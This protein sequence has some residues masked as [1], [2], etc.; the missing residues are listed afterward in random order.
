[1]MDKTRIALTMALEERQEI[2]D[3]ADGRLSASAFVNAVEL[4]AV[5]RDG[6]EVWHHY[7]LIG[8]VL[9]GVDSAPVGSG[10][11]FVSGLRARLALEPDLARASVAVETPSIA[12][13]TVKV[14]ISA[15]D[16]SFRWRMVAALASLTAVL[17]VGWNMVEGIQTAN[18]ARVAAL[19]GGQKDQ[20]VLTKVASGS[21]SDKGP[22][23]MLRD[24]HL[25]ALMAAHKQFG[26]TS[27]LQMPAGFIRNATFESDSK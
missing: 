24:P 16:S 8:D 15:N 14:G 22:Q 17:V 6:R 10:M 1:M 25:D 2:S 21:P 27:A 19:A 23:I 13:V 3:L 9:R 20:Q 11:D 5:N 26:G 18:G 12:E 4:A 7:H